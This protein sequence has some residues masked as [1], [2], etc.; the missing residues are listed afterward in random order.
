MDQTKGRGGARPEWRSRKG[1]VRRR[2]YDG[3]RERPLQSSPGGGDRKVNEKD[4]D[5]RT[6]VRKD[7]IW[8]TWNLETDLVGLG[9]GLMERR[10]DE[11]TKRNSDEL[12][13]TD[14]V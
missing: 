7:R 13:D 10:G 6:E 12:Y 14:G 4:D 3:G 8:K 1:D 2:R 5:P 11:I 9:W